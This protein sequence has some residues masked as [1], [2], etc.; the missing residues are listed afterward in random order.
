[1][2][3]IVQMEDIELTGVAL[4]S[5]R[6]AADERF[7]KIAVAGELIEWGEDDLKRECVGTIRVAGDDAES[8]HLLELQ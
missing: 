1:M 3:V 5:D 2:F 6:Q 8:V 7:E 4:L